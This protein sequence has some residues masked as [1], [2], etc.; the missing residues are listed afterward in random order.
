MKPFLN[1]INKHKQQCFANSYTYRLSIEKGC[2]VIECSRLKHIS[3][4]VLGGWWG[5]GGVGG[6]VL[7]SFKV[8]CFGLLPLYD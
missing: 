4:C 2:V 5:W 6:G 3:V 8:T 1:G 7:S